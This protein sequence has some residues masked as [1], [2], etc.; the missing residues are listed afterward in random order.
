MDDLRTSLKALSESIRR[1]IV[2]TRDMS[3]RLHPARLDRFGLIP[4]LREL[5]DELGE[6]SRCRVDFRSVGVTPAT[7]DSSL[8]ITVYRLVGEAF[9]NIGRY[10]HAKRVNLRL[11]ASSPDLFLAIEDDGKGLDGGAD[12]ASPREEKLL[13]LSIMK[14][15][16]TLLQ[17]EMKIETGTEGGTRLRFGFPLRGPGE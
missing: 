2:L 8:A 10:A 5:C 14:E 16:A 12:A 1:S 9:R 7:L 17:G 4:V 6:T 11:S 3:Q 15:R 13:G